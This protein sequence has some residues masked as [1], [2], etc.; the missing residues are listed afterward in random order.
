MTQSPFL[1]LFICSLYVYV[2]KFFGPSL[3]KN[4]EPLDIRWLMVFYNFMMV[5]FNFLIF[6]GFGI[7][8]WFGS[9]S[10]KC[11]PVDYSNSTE[12]LGML[13][14]C[15]WFYI[16]KMVEFTDTIFFVMRKKFNQITTL[17]V[18]HHGILPM[19]V[20]FGL[21]FTPGGHSTFFA[22]INSFVHVLMYCYYGLAAIGPHMNKYLWWKKYMTRIQMIQ[23]VMIFTHAFQLLFRDCNYPQGFAWWIGFHSVLFWF[24]FA[25]FY[26]STYRKAKALKAKDTERNETAQ[27]LK[28]GFATMNGHSFSCEI[29]NSCTN[30]NGLSSSNGI[31]SHTD[32]TSDL[33][34]GYLSQSDLVEPSVEKKVN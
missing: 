11:Q 33:S 1:T 8:G 29:A 15:W 30:Q 22:F 24:L 9:Y 19:S 32:S 10:Y 31:H 4:R 7:Y 21:K 20:W 17:H 6:Y 25:D 3:M 34:N 2:V 13:K 18:V 27:T 12:A 23:F 28:N 26:R 5:I 14:V 16:S